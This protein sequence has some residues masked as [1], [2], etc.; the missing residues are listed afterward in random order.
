MSLNMKMKI[1]FCSF[2]S[3]FILSFNLWSSDFTVVTSLEK[4]PAGLI[5]RSQDVDRGIPFK[6]NDV[7]ITG[8]LKEIDYKRE[9]IVS[10]RI[11]YE[12][13]S[14][15]GLS[16]VF[17]I[18]RLTFVSLKELGNIPDSIPE[19]TYV[20]GSQ[21]AFVPY[22]F[23]VSTEVASALTLTSSLLLMNSL[24]AGDNRDVR[25]DIRN[26]LFISAG[27]MATLF[28]LYEQLSGKTKP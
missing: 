13:N 3:I 10:G 22:S 8:K 20:S 21:S 19:P 6:T 11:D 1:N 25:D 12:K 9:A 18:E 17:V 28:F 27:T 16:S 15:G 14:D 7:L 26:G 2:V 5:M 24:T 23:P 4:T